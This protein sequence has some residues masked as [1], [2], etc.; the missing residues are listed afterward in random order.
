MSVTIKFG[1]WFQCRLA[2]DPD[3]SDEPRGV[4]GYVHALPGEP[5]LDR[6]IRTQPAGTTP[7]SHCP[8]IGVRVLALEGD[9]RFDK[10]P[11]VG[12]AVDLLDTPKFEGRNHILAEDGLE[13][14]V[15][16]NLQISL[17]GF[18]LTRRFDDNMSFPPFTQEDK[19]KFSQLQASGIN[20]SPGTIGEATGIYDLAGVWKARTAKL[21]E[22]L[23]ETNDEIQRAALSARILA[24]SN[25][26]NARFFSARMLY[27]LALG[28]RAEVNDPDS[29]LPGTA[30]LNTDTPWPLEFWF[31]GWDPD[32][33]SG[34]MEGYLR[35]SFADAP[36]AA[37]LSTGIAR[38][39]SDPLERRR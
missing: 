39:M 28:G 18:R 24:M 38:M 5:D 33:L 2:T 29:W 11:L 14:V 31:G 32:A 6:I 9:N 34:Y 27:S 37:S 21:Q 1:G 30:A 23:D 3:P 20:I 15:P 25:P 22:D 19:Q 4:S 13:A 17:E 36:A 10:H 26:A 8:L 12:A 35:I 7:R 16:C